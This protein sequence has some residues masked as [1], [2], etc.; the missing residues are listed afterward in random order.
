MR[1]FTDIDLQHAVD[2][3]VRA[4]AIKQ[5]IEISEGTFQFSP[6]VTSEQRKLVENY[7]LLLLA[8]GFWSKDE[9][10]ISMANL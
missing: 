7:V 1:I 8:A 2:F 9:N 3:S 4:S 10:T 6:G 5:L